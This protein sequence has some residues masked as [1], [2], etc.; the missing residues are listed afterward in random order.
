[1]RVNI[2]LCP[3][4]LYILP[5]LQNP[6]ICTKEFRFT[7]CFARSLHFHIFTLQAS[8]LCTAYIF[9]KIKIVKNLNIFFTRFQNRTKFE[10]AKSSKTGNVKIRMNTTTNNLQDFLKFDDEL[11]RDILRKNKNRLSANCFE[12]SL[13]A[14]L[15]PSEESGEAS[16]IFTSRSSNGFRSNSMNIYRT[17]DTL[18]LNTDIVDNTPDSTYQFDFKNKE[19]DLCM[20]KHIR[21]LVK[22]SYKCKKI[23]KKKVLFNLVPF[24]FCSCAIQL[25]SFT[26]CMS[27]SLTIVN[28]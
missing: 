15:K 5:T 7:F 27:L 28:N 20:S 22:I 8:T 12:S 18:S 14:G 2:N 10:N 19:N 17:P 9:I 1:M 25:I 6:I 16:S 4:W 3:D 26:Y 13:R 23:I 11:Y 21:E 24:I